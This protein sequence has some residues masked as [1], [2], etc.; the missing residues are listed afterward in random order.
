MPQHALQR[1][2][3]LLITGFDPIAVMAL[4]AFGG[5]WATPVLQLFVVCVP[6]S[7]ICRQGAPQKKSRKL[8]K[9]VEALMASKHFKAGTK[10]L[11]DI[12]AFWLWLPPWLLAFGAFLQLLFLNCFRAC[13]LFGCLFELSVCR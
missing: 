2:I 10:K 4:R 5:L 11:A 13:L 1:H 7:C 12:P 8:D 3:L 6:A 9:Q